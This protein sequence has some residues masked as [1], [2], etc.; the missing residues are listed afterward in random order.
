MGNVEFNHSHPRMTRDLTRALHYGSYE[1]PEIELIKRQIKPN[2]RVI[3]LGVGIGATSLILYDLVGPEN[4][5]VFDADKRTIGM[6]KRNLEL[7]ITTYGIIES[8]K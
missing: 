7:I 4:L 6:A 5:C 8:M 3:E 2:D 1:L